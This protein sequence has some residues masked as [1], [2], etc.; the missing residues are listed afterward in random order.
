MFIPSIYKSA[1]QVIT[2]NSG[3]GDYA[4][5]SID[6]NYTRVTPLGYP[7]A[8]DNGFVNQK[9]LVA[10]IKT[11]T[12]L[13]IVAGAETGTNAFAGKVLIEEYLPLFFR[14]VF[15][16][17]NIVVTDNNL[18]NTENTG[19]TLSSKAY[20]LPMGWNG[21]VTIEEGNI[22]AASVQVGFSLVTATGIVTMS[23]NRCPGNGGSLTG[24]FMVIDPK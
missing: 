7:S 12:L 8:N 18:N 17:S 10:R 6:P 13:E 15:Y 5:S 11:A 3:N 4:I 20:V 1:P 14:Q 23:R 2:I 19:L 21:A 9:Y 16:R 22:A 24:Y